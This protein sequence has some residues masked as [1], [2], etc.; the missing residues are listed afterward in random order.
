MQLEHSHRAPP[1]PRSPGQSL[2]GVPRHWFGGNMVATHVANGVNLLFPAGE[3]FFVRSVK[4]YTDRIDDPNL[5]ARVR[6][7]F[8]QEGRHAK[9][10]D[11]FNRILEAQGYDCLLY[12]SP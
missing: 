8:G 7:F 11:V 5:Q 3:R 10:H 6:G 9:E 2:E 4:H 12:T 1:K